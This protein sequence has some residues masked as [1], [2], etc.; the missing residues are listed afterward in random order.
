MR[1]ISQNG[2]HDI[3]YE[4]SAVSINGTTISAYSHSVGPTFMAQYKS[5]DEARRAM[6]QLRNRYIEGKKVYQ[7]PD[8]VIRV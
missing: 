6:M 7:F 2:E 5:R 3:P 1:V 4:S 8:K